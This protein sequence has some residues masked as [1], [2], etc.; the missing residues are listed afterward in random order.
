MAEYY[1]IT[2]TTTKP[3]DPNI[4]WLGDHPEHTDST[5]EF[6]DWHKEQPGHVRYTDKWISENV[7]QRCHYFVDK[8]SA[9]L[10]WKA[11][12]EHPIGQQRRKYLADHGFVSVTTEEVVDEELPPMPPAV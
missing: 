12:A 10:W 11:R 4:H 6:L 3:E 9:D 2:I 8:Q 7:F 5:L 1:K